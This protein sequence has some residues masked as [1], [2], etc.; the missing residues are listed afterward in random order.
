MV[1]RRR[2][3]VDLLKQLTVQHPPEHGLALPTQLSLNLA[4][5]G[6]AEVGDD[7]YDLELLLGDL[8][9]LRQ[10]GEPAD[11]LLR[12]WERGEPDLD[13]VGHR[14]EPDRGQP[15]GDPE[16][17]LADRRDADV[18]RRG[19]VGERAAPLHDQAGG[20][21]GEMV[22][23]EPR[24]PP[25]RRRDDRRDLEPERVPELRVRGHR[26][27]PPAPL[28]LAEDRRRHLRP[29]RRL[30]QG[31]P[32]EVAPGPELLGDRGERRRGGLTPPATRRRSCGRIDLG[33]KD[34]HGEPCEYGRGSWRGL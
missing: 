6:H 33:R 17:P 28:D 31:Q 10:F 30:A 15:V 34:G 3:G 19:E 20:E 1:D 9:D 16:H 25:G 29:R 14:L 11:R 7:T 13:I 24:L 18:E 22:A 27:D 12:S 26:G 32:K 2:A 8:G 5:G 21:R 23:L 4:A